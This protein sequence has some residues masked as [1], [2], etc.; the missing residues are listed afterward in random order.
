MVKR[1]IKRKQQQQTKQCQLAHTYNNANNSNKNN[2]SKP[3][4][5]IEAAR[6]V[7]E[8]KATVRARGWG[9]TF[10]VEGKLT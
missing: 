1:L 8:Q 7:E 4:A 9:C 5:L 2:P 6:V 3:Q 10:D